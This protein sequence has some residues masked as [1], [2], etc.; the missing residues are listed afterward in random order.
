MLDTHHLSGYWDGF[1]AQ[2]YENK[3]AFNFLQ[4]DTLFQCDWVSEKRCIGQKMG[5]LSL[6]KAKNP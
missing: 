4:L 5:E 6:C 1:K 3:K 2:R